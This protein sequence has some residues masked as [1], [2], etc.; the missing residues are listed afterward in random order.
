MKSK[1]QRDGSF[2]QNQSFLLYRRHE[3]RVASLVATNELNSNNQNACCKVVSSPV[4]SGGAKR[5]RGRASVQ[6]LYL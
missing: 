5:N 1:E 3:F 2:F 4:A 6:P